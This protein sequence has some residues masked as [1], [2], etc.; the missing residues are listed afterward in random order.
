MASRQE[1]RKAERD[2]AKAAAGVAAAR[3]RVQVDPD[4]DWTT[5]EEDCEVLFRALGEAL[6]KQIADEGTP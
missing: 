1:R 5:Q 3:A 6:V 2:A 4:G